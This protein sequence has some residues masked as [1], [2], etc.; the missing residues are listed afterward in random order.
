M[1]ICHAWPSQ[2][3]VGY[4]TTTVA[5]QLSLRKLESGHNSHHHRN[6]LLHFFANENKLMEG[7]MIKEFLESW[8]MHYMKKM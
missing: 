6:Q 5:A 1:L 8:R 3:R 7:E 2:Y 4:T